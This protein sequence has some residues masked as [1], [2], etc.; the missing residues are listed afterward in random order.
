DDAR[1][2]VM[3]ILAERPQSETALRLAFNLSRGRTDAPAL[4]DRLLQ[5]HPSCANLA[6]A[7]KFYSSTA[8]QDKAAQLEQQLSVCA[9]ESLQYARTLAESGRHGAAA[10]FLQQFIV[11]N[12]LHRSARRL[13]VEQ[14][15]LSSQQ[16]AARLQAQQ[17]SD[18]A[19]NAG[20]YARLVDAP[21]T[22]Q[23]SR[24]RRAA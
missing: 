19:P 10:A 7:V 13:L 12:A 15:V 23:D 22:V 14:L 4:L 1:Q 9:P 6:E 5:V 17:L 8:E 3:A 21:E 24:S 18:L 2:D 16:S 11:R 20:S